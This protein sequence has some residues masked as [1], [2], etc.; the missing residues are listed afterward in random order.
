M[1][2]GQIDTHGAIRKD[3]SNRP[4]SRRKLPAATTD[5]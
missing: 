4:L 1:G 2:V 5:S 3:A